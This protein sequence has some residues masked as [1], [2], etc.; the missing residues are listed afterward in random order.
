M[1]RYCFEHLAGKG[2]LPHE[3][4]LF[5]LNQ[6]DDVE[7]HEL[8]PRSLFESAG[9]IA[10]VLGGPLFRGSSPWCKGVIYSVKG[11]CSVQV[12]TQRMERDGEQ[13]PRDLDEWPR[14]SQADKLRLLHESI[15]CR[16]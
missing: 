4:S 9:T 14:I 6:V 5:P 13:Q 10:L 8:F 11:C 12:D 1:A 7:D 2:R 15:S 16:C 3:Q